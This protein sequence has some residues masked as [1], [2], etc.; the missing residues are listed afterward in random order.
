MKILLADYTKIYKD[1]QLTIDLFNIIY[2]KSFLSSLVEHI[3]EVTI[4]SAKNVFEND[5]SQEEVWGESDC[6]V[7]YHFPTQT[8]D[9]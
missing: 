2:L 6:Y 8:P 9:G 5:D 7:Q 3:L 1:V 4:E